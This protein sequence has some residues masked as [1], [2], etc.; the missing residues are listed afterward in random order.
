MSDKEET[1]DERRRR[2]RAEDEE[3]ETQL[4]IISW[5]IAQLSEKLYE[6]RQAGNDALAEELRDEQT[7][8]TLLQ[9]SL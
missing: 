9:L 7:R 5:Q 1:V 8:L 4:D 6:A 3:R 2:M